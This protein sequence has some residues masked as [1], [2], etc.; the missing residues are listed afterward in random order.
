V[1]SKELRIRRLEEKFDFEFG[2]VKSLSRSLDRFV[3]DLA[4]VIGLA[5]RTENKT[6]RQDVEI[7]QLWKALDALTEMAD[8]DYGEDDS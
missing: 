4:R 3:G 5:Q 6:A 1:S 8:P 7:D 2:P